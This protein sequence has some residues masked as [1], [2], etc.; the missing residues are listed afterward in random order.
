MALIKCPECGKEISDSAGTCINCGASFSLCPECGEPVLRSVSVCQNCGFEAPHPHE[1]RGRTSN[2]TKTNLDLD[3][4][5]EGTQDLQT[6]LKEYQLENKKHKT[7]QKAYKILYNIF[8]RI[9]FGF[10]LPIL[11]A[12]L[13][14]SV[15]E[16]GFVEAMGKLGTRFDSFDG[17]LGW[18]LFIV[19]AIICLSIYVSPFQKL[20]EMV[21]LME[22]Y[23]GT[24]NI[25][26]DFAKTVERLRADKKEEDV[27]A[28]IEKGQSN[29]SVWRILLLKHS[30]KEAL[31]FVLDILLSFV[32]VILPFVY[33]IVYII[34]SSVLPIFNIEG[35]EGIVA[36]V[37]MIVLFIVKLL[38]WGFIVR[39][40]GKREE[41]FI[42][43]CEDEG[44][45]KPLPET[46]KEE[47]I[48]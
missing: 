25:P 45:I 31:P 11:T 13:I 48:K 7:F 39:L 20:G 4:L 9:P 33:L 30:T 35:M 2:A 26:Y 18:G 23:Y 19:S 15:R 12:M 27:D 29:E 22:L 21:C 43:F 37:S 1:I 28:V 5:P 36:M 34:M 16:G 47:N 10:V 32:S 14:L 17:F 24:K 46:N 38:L 3:N 6:V 40:E 42:K 41:A 8:I 44:I